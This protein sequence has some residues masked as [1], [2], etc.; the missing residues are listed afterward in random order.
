MSVLDR[1]SEHHPLIERLAGRG[2]IANYDER[3]AFELKRAV[4]ARAEEA[5][6]K[7]DFYAASLVDVSPAEEIDSPMGDARS[8]ACSASLSARR[9]ALIPTRSCSRC[10]PGCLSEP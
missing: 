3:E 8:C 10:I 4:L 9:T 2:V 5:G 7:L 1:I 6:T